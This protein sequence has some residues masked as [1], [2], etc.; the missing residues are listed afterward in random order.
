VP[1][2]GTCSS[3]CNSVEQR[4]K[5]ACSSPSNSVHNAPQVPVP[6]PVTR[7][8]TP[9]NFLSPLSFILAV[10][11]FLYFPFFLRFCYLNHNI[12]FIL[13]YGCVYFP[14]FV[15]S[16]FGYLFLFLHTILSFT[17]FRR[18]SKSNL[19][20]IR[21]FF[22]ASVSII[23]QVTTNLTGPAGR[24]AGLDKTCH[25]V[26]AQNVDRSVLRSIQCR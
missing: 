11:H 19:K 24:P 6:P 10:P 22:S 14:F 8:T 7:F 26:P 12:F 20:S 9:H 3:P 23:Q 17:A 13:F 1:I 15:P 18:F 2:F 16:F 5:S 4:P 25:R 21:H